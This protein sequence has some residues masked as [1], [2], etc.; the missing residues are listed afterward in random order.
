MATAPTIGSLSLSKE[1]GISKALADGANNS[2]VDG[3]HQVDHSPPVNGLSQIIRKL[4]PGLHNHNREQ[5]TPNSLLLTR[6]KIK[7]YCRLPHQSQSHRAHGES[8]QPVLWAHLYHLPPL[9][10]YRNSITMVVM[11]SQVQ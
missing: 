5:R 10:H 2:L 11:I 1:R 3:M 9:L 8:N 4:I 7:E 6:R